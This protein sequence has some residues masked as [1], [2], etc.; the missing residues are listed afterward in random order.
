[1]SSLHVTKKLREIRKPALKSYNSLSPGYMTP[2]TWKAK[3][4]TCLRRK[5]TVFKPLSRA[6]GQTLSVGCHRFDDTRTSSWR[7]E[8][9][10]RA[11]VLPKSSPRVTPCQITQPPKPG[12]LQAHSSS[13]FLDQSLSSREARVL[14]R[15]SFSASSLFYSKASCAV[16]Q[17]SPH[18]RDAEECGASGECRCSS[19]HN[20]NH[21]AVWKLLRLQCLNSG[22]PKF[23]GPLCKD[24]NLLPYPIACGSENLGWS[25]YS[26]GAFHSWNLVRNILVI[27]WKIKV[28]H[29]HKSKSFGVR[30]SL[31]WIVPLTLLH[32]MNY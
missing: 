7:Q 11:A 4:Q 22:V 30:Q 24:L 14:R 8:E 19:Y 10:E 26:G 3:S 17:S 6:R 25:S 32:W 2:N 29:N 27:I 1:M 31:V 5:G 20:A 28:Q 12:S 16:I 18:C 13:F 21:H 23:R 9:C 15:S